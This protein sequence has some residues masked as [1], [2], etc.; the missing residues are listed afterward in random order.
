[1]I[2]SIFNQPADYFLDRIIVYKMPENGEKC[3]L[4]SKAMS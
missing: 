2:I 4:K 3:F 1:M